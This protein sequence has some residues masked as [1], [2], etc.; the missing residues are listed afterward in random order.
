MK[1][2]FF[3]PFLLLVL[4]LIILGFINISRKLAWKEPYDGVS[5]VEGPSGLIAARV[6]EDSPAYLSGLKAG[7]IL[8]S[9]NDTPIKNRIEFA[10]MLWLI[11]RL[12]QKALYQVGRSGTILSPSFYLTKKG[13]SSTYIYLM[14]LGLATLAISLM[15]FFNTKRQFTGPL[16]LFLSCFFIS[17]FFLCFLGYRPDGFSRPAI[18]LA[19]QAGP[20]SFP[21]PPSEFLLHLSPEEKNNS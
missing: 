2:G 14:L 17:L 10:K 8:F 20:V 3:Y 18:L 6:D 9:I 7:D 13:V 16:R 1:R 12:E 11:D 19:G 5:W 21:S 15:V 4:F